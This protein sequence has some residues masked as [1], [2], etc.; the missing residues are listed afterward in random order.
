[1][2]MIVW[3]AIGPKGGG[4]CQREGVQAGGRECCSFDVE[5]CG[6]GREHMNRSSGVKCT[7]Q[8]SE[9]IID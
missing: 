4:L 9:C 5:C 6:G 2:P 3:K 7:H 8:E 1:M